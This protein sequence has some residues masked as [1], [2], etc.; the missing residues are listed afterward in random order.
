MRRFL[1]FVLV[2]LMLGAIGVG[3]I[4]L[5]PT[6]DSDTP[7]ARRFATEQEWIQADIVGAITG[8]I[9]LETPPGAGPI[10]VRDHVWSP[11]TYAPLVERMLAG[12]QLDRPAA[13][14]AADLAVRAVL[15]DLRSE[16]LL[17]QNERVSSALQQSILHAGWQESAALL[18]GGLA[19]RESVGL[20]SDVR[21]ALSRM[22][23]HLAIA[24]ALR[25]S[26]EPS[27]DGRCALAILTALAG[28]ER[29]AVQMVNELETRAVSPA[30]RAW[31]RA[32]RVR[33]TGD[34]RS[35]QNA[36]TLLERLEFARAV[37]GRLGVDRFLDY[38][39]TFAP[40]P[41]ADWHRIAFQN[42]FTVEAG[43]RFTANNV[44][45]DLREASL[46]WS[47]LH[48]AQSIG[49]RDVVAALN[50]RPRPSPLTRSAQGA[51][52]QV[53]DWGT[54][55]AFEQRQLSMSLV[56]HSTHLWALA[57]YGAQRE[58]QANQDARFGRLTLYPFVLRWGAPTAEIYS[59]AM[60]GA[61]AVIERSP[62]LVTAAEWNF[63]LSKPSFTNVDARFPLEQTWFTPAVP[64][65]TA[66]DLGSRSLREGCPRPPTR[67]QAATWARD[68][69]YQHWTVWANEFLAL[70][71]G[72][73]SL[74]VVQRAFGSLVD[75]DTGALLK[76]IDYLDMS[77]SARIDVAQRLC[78]ISP[79]DCDR[80]AQLLLTAG[81]EKDAVMAYERWIERA[82]DRVGVSRGVTWIVRYYH[83]Q[84]RS[85]RAEE[86]ARHAADVGSGPG[87]EVLGE[88]LDRMGRH[89]EAEEI[90]RANERRYRERS[91]TLGQFLMRQ[92][93]RTGDKSLQ[94]KAGELLRP[95]FPGGLEPVAMHA[96]PVTPADGIQV[97][98]VGP[99]VM[100]TGLRPGDVI[101][102]V[103]QWRVHNYDQYQTV[104]R[105]A[106]DDTMTLTVWR[107][108]RCEQLRT[109]V[110]QR[111]FG[112]TIH[113]YR[114]PAGQAR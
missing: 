82:R 17:E 95:V 31:V 3:T 8:M 35:S 21:P 34:W 58:W 70:D 88:L 91:V 15:T 45:L 46:A 71:Q 33:I 54:W 43:R 26:A 53:L 103:D 109:I 23:A 76:I 32:L 40:E 2:G 104:S 52:V 65:G 19:L 56:S 112:S 111:W 89:T 44:E 114:A 99:R 60:S 18:V 41:I 98:P 39:D 75:Y 24:R 90:Y 10:A 30:D 102:G 113:T 13:N 48:G 57:A 16:T 6:Q 1:V 9:A 36:G 50:D 5:F 29:Q 51:V 87:L 74:P 37:R 69:P 64:D 73:P 4:N 14:D 81:R 92:A 28:L 83:A 67:A 25:G 7:P 62:E 72:K 68:Q 85:D 100:K 61:R 93:L 27:M 94:A 84:G 59:A 22:A 110:P 49:E 77:D 101:V 80:L 78:A 105:L 96:L 66:F 12:R 107:N 55:A 86:I 38:L 11:A 47:R 20:F 42:D 97:A 79:T 63:M 108:G 106:F